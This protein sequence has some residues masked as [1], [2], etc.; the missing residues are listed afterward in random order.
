MRKKIVT[1]IN[2]LLLC[3]MVLHVGGKLLLH[4]QHPEYSA[5]AYVELI[6]AVYYL[7]PIILVNLGYRIFQKSKA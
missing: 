3:A 1:V 6:N 7:I 5:P 2:I 4:F